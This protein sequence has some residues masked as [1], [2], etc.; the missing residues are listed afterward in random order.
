MIDIEDFSDDDLIQEFCVVVRELQNRGYN[1][2][3]Q[4]L[5]KEVEK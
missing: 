1:A 4:L 2:V 3:M 5:D